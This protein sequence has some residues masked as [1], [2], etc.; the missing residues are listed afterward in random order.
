MRPSSWNLSSE[1]LLKP[2][3]R[4]MVKSFRTL[5]LVN[6]SDWH[7]MR[8]LE[9]RIGSSGGALNR[10]SVRQFRRASTLSIDPRGNPAHLTPLVDA[11]PIREQV[12]GAVFSQAAPPGTRVQ[13]HDAALLAEIRCHEH[14]HMVVRGKLGQLSLVTLAAQREWAVSSKHRGCHEPD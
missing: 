10:I 9:R 8:H 7:A 1:A 6:A 12:F 13:Q 14:P 3:A 11:N 4:G 2:D 5:N